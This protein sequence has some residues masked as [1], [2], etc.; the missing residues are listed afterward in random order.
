[1]LINKDHM[2]QEPQ[3]L[4]YQQNKQQQSI[5]VQGV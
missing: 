4:I 1:M 2:I 3:L 5:L